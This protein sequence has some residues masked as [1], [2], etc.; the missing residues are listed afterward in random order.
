VAG[1]IVG[2]VTGAGGCTSAGAGAAGA[3]GDW[4]P[5]LVMSRTAGDGGFV[6]GVFS[7]PLLPEAGVGFGPAGW[8]G[9]DSSDEEEEVEDVVSDSE[10]LVSSMRL[11][12]PA[13]LASF[14]WD[15]MPGLGTVWGVGCKE[16]RKKDW[17]S[18]RKIVSMRMGVSNPWKLVAPLSLV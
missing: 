14:S 8:L 10:E 18:S 17:T 3:A 12:F 11:G 7:P 1:S 4:L 13:R 16:E 6:L 9:A 2:T 15:M 5:D